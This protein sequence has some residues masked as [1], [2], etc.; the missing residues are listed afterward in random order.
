MINTESDD[1]QMNNSLQFK[2]VAE[3]TML[4]ISLR[5]F[6]EDM[7][8]DINSESLSGFQF[9]QLPESRK[10][11]APAQAKQS[12]A[13]IYHKLNELVIDLDGA[14]PAYNIYG[15][16]TA[17]APPR[18]TK[19]KDYVSTFSIIDESE[20]TVDLVLFFSEGS[21]PCARSVG[22]I[23]R[24]HRMALTQ[25]HG[26]LQGNK[27]PGTA[28]LLFDGGVGDAAPAAP[29]STAAWISALSGRAGPRAK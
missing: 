12:K 26:K 27:G 21:S 4:G 13:I 28:I 24:V 8:L 25:H 17:Y 10:R 11:K 19:G 15:V 14:A 2:L 3:D 1:S 22:D 29:V 9:Q 7:T 5:C 6:F 23:I 20:A 16:I 18:P